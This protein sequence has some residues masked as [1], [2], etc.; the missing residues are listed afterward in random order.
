MK[1]NCRTEEEEEKKTVDIKKEKKNEIKENICEKNSVTKYYGTIKSITTN[2]MENMK[3]T[4]LNYVFLVF[5]CFKQLSIL[6]EVLFL[7]IIIKDFTHAQIQTNMFFFLLPIPFLYFINDV[8]QCS[9]YQRKD[10][11]FFDFFLLIFVM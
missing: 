4:R 10:I 11:L 5:W 8:L 7:L 3:F 6:K 9:P 2:S 1:P